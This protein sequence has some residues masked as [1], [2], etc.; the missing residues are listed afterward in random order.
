MVNNE[1]HLCFDV[2]GCI[3]KNVFESLKFTIDLDGFDE[4]MSDAEE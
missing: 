1:P 4:A 2:L 3:D